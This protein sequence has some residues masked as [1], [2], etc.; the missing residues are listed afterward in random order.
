MK[1]KKKPILSTPANFILSRFGIVKLT[2]P[3]HFFFFLS[4]PCGL[5]PD[6]C[7][8]ND[9]AWLVKCLKIVYFLNIIKKYWV[10]QHHV[11]YKK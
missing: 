9:I 1:K 3:E 8:K 5:V 10:F 2:H 6:I 4:G 7:V 11:T